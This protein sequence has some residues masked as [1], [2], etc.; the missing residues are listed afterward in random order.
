MDFSE[1]FWPTGLLDIALDANLEGGSSSRVVHRPLC[2]DECFWS[3]S[4]FRHRYAEI[5][6]AIPSTG[7]LDYG[8]N[9]ETCQKPEL[10]WRIADLPQ[11]GYVVHALASHRNCRTLYS[12]LLASKYAEEG[13]ISLQVSRIRKIQ[14]GNKVIYPISILA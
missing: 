11:P 8:W 13:T 9:D 2:W 3:I 12:S 7:N 1:H 4:A 10:L 14:G 6:C 5:H